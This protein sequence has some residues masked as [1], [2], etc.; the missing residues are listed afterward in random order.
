MWLILIFFQTLNLYFIKLFSEYNFFDLLLHIIWNLKYWALENHRSEFLWKINFKRLLKTLAL[1]FSNR[2]LSIMKTKHSVCRTSDNKISN[3][4]SIYQILQ[5][6][7]KSAASAYNFNCGTNW[8]IHLYFLR[9][10]LQVSITLEFEQIK[11]LGNWSILMVMPHEE[12]LFEDG[13]GTKSPTL[14]L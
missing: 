7:K 6:H 13:Y 10:S 4:F 1:S 14:V 9:I 5:H 8:I 12:S 3:P 11:I 2:N